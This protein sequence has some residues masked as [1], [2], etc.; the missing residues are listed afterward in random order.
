M[1]NLNN[2]VEQ[3]QLRENLP[4]QSDNIN[5]QQKY[6]LLDKRLKEI[7]GMNDL[8][9]VDLRELSLVPDVVISP[10]FKMP[11]V[12]ITKE[13]KAFHGELHGS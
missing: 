5:L 7:E 2:H 8:G 4:R 9:S 13:L 10:K 6:N 12:D 3:E 1:S 11:N